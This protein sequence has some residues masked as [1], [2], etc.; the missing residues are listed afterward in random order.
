MVIE[1]G[2][3][4]RSCEEDDVCGTAMYV[5][6]VVCFQSIKIINGKCNEF[7]FANQDIFLTI[8]DFHIADKGKEESAMGVY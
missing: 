6:D 4:G 7:V 1:N 3:R 2:S 5:D 8:H